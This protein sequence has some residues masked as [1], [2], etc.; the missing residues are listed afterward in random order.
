MINKSQTAEIRN[1][2]ASK[3]L[4]LDLF[5]EVEDHFLSQISQLMKDK[6]IGFQEAFLQTK[7]LWIGELRMVRASIL[8]FKKITVIEKKIVDRSL[9]RILLNSFLIVP[10]LIWFCVTLPYAVIFIQIILLAILFS[11]VGLSLIKKKLKF[12]DYLFLGFHPLILKIILICYLFSYLLMP[13]LIANFT[14]IEFDPIFTNGFLTVIIAS[15]AQ[16]QLLYADFNNKKVL[17]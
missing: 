7:I 1:Y 3:K 10:F 2:L 12:R 9:N 15:V 14:Q 8:S 5:L 4:Q 11:I 16:I 13:F 17:L 6:N